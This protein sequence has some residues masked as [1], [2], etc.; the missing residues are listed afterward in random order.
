GGNFENLVADSDAA[1]T[2]INDDADET[3]LT[4]TATDT[5]SEGGTITYTATL[6]NPADTAMTVTLSNGEVINIAAGDTSG[7][8]DVVTNND[9]YA[10]DSSASASI[11]SSSGG[12]FENLIVDT[13]EA[14]TTIVDS[15]DATNLTLTANDTVVEGGTITYTASLDNPAGTAMTVT[16]NNGQVIS[17]AAGTTSGTVDVI[18][19]DDVYGGGDTASAAI[20]SVSGGNFENLVVDNAPASTTISDDADESNLTLSATDTVNEGDTITYTATLDNPADT[21]MTVTLSNGEVINIGAGETTGTVDVVASDDVYAGGDTASATIVS[22]SGGNFENLVVD[23]APAST[24]ISDDADESNL[25]LSATDTVTEGGTITYTATLDNPADTAMTVTLSN[26]EVINIAAG[27][28]SGTVDVVTNNDVYAGDSSASASIVSS[29][30]GNFENLI[31]DTSE[32][33]TTIVDSGDATNL[34]LTANDT[35]VEGATITYTATLDN[36]ADTAMTVTLSNGEVINIGA[37]ETTGTVDVVA[38]DDVYAGGDTASATIVST[39]GG[40]FENL[41]VDNAPASTT[42]SDDADESNLTLSATDTVTEGGTITYTATLDNPA[43]TAMT[44]TLSNGEVINI[45][46]GDTSGTVDVVTNNDVYAGDSSASA[47]I[48]SSSGGNFENLIVDTSEATTTIVDSGDATNLT[49]TA[50]DTVVEGGTITY[51]AILDNPADTAMT[52]TLS[53]GEVINIAAGGTSGTVDVIASDDVYA[54]GDTAS[55]TIASTSGGNFANL[56]VDSDAATT[57]VSDDADESNLTLSAIDTVSE[58]GT[59]TYTATLDNPADTAMTVTLSNGEVINI[60]AGE[61]TGT[62]D[63]VASDDVYAGGDTASA[64][65]ASTSGGNFENLV[66]DNAPASTTIS[67]DADESNLTLSA[68]DTVNEGGTITYTATLDNPAD[69]A[70]TVTLNNGE[71]I[72]I[73]AGETTGT[74]DIVASDDAYAG[75]DTA[76]ATIIS[77][78]G[79]NFENLVVDSTPATT[80]INDDADTTN[81]TLSATDTVAEGGTITYTA[82]LDNP[83]ASAMT[84][85]LSNGLV[86]SIAAGAVSGTIDA[87]ASDDVYAGGDSASAAITST[88]G[89]G[90]ENLVADTNAAT[91]SITDDGDVTNLTLTASDTVSEGGTITYTASLD[92]PAGTAMTVTLNNGQVISIAAGATS[93]TVDVIASDDV[94]GGGDTASAAI[95][96]VSGGNFENLVADS[97]AATTTTINDDADETNL[98]LTAT[99]TVSE[100]GTITYTATLDNPADTAMTVTLSNGEVIN[101]AAGETTGTVDVIAS[102]DA[103]AGGDTASAAITSASGGNFENLVVD[104][105]PASTTISDDADESNLTL[106]ATDTVTEGGTI[107]YTATLDN[108]ADTAMTVTLSNGEVINI[109][110]GDTS[111]T[112]DVIASDD[113][114]AG[115]DA[116]SAS[117]TSTSGGNFENLVVDATPATTTINDDVDTT[118]VTLSAT[119]TVAE[120]GTITYT[121]TLDNPAD[122]AM[123]VTLSNGQVVSIAAGATSGTVDV[124]ASDDVYAGG[125]TASAT[126][127]STSGGNFENLVVDDTP[128]T[129]TIND[130]AD[131]TNVTLSATDTVAEGGTI[132]FTATLDNPAASAM[133]V[134]LSNGLVISIAAGA[135]SG[136]IDAT[137]SD[138]V[139]AGGDSASAAITATD[140]GGFENLVADT[141]AATTSITDDGDVTNL[142]LTASDT[143]SEGGTITYTASLDNPAGT[144]MTVT[145]NNGQVISIAA[146][147]TSGTVDVIASDDVYGGG[148]TASAAI[149][150]VS[151]GNFENLVADSDAATTTINDDADETNLTLSATD[152][153][154]EGGTI[155][156]TATLDNPAG[157][158]MTVTLSNGQVISIAAGATS[159]TVDV[160]ASDDVYAGGDTASATIAS[161][162]GGNL[163]NLVVDTTPAT[164]TISDDADESNLTLSATDTVTEGG[165]IT[166]TATLDNPADTAMTVTLSNGEVINIAAGDTSGTVDV[167]ASDD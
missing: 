22:T 40:N 110:A 140:G 48:V 39:S 82:T 35:V 42:I 76:S 28:T 86:I 64:T 144:A 44:V 156:Y 25:T 165:T 134:T 55:A 98:T 51:T 54:G 43:D 56:V 139:Y 36:P 147:A 41:V 122:T 70:M 7:T 149:D 124:V 60:A 155:T 8:V 109:A 100:G 5:V 4:L 2:T 146:G 88:D 101:I 167:I 160:V 154:S 77:T 65:I 137:A 34:T 131:T 91:T 33:A 37:G 13:S 162:S 10:G 32:A 58:G 6:D 16:L 127:A 47:S 85:T 83:A 57:T 164:T 29:S 138:D 99:D 69:T 59:I 105:T 112:V 119:D 128:A 130:D 68:T 97:D 120:G 61:T 108:P 19:S 75:G 111:G 21:A 126:I 95:D 80:T 87:T 26:G 107:T 45:A 78:N 158:A 113:A 18:A 24:T 92:N 133:T 115:G 161:T 150:S 23:N 81:V 38:S 166:Y 129:T 11:V 157:T 1:T 67:D 31:V 79:G 142:T 50:N 103:Y 96:S 27:D 89:G 63:V 93:G 135:V 125:D 12:N 20:D 132:T 123:T 106:S 84:V 114:Y 3:N 71:V 151:G 153:V 104:E 66:V 72:N 49:L 73:A 53:N 148:D 121:A 30:G 143:V 163:E 90:F 159:G 9:V 14:T 62:V 152:T 102:D 74:V 141:N 118:N 94:Y 116:A 17:I 145:L 136:T 46:A 52:V 117:I 15:G